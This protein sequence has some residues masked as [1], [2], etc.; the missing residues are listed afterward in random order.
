MR[1][2]VTGGA[3]FI[4]SHLV[5]ELICRGH[6]V[7]VLD[8]LSQ[9]DEGNIAHHLGSPAFEFIRGDVTE[10]S[11]V[12]EAVANSDAVYHLAAVVGVYY[13]L[14]DPI[15]TISVNTVGTEVVLRMAFRHK[16][17]VL[18]A[19]SSEVYGKRKGG[20]LS[21]GDDLVFGPTGVPRWCYALTKALDEHLALAYHRRGLEVSVVRYFNVYGPRLDPRGYGSVV[22]RF[23]TQA[24]DGRPITVYGDGTQTRSFTY[25]ADS[26]RGT[27]LAATLPQAVGRVFNIGNGREVSILEL[28]RLVKE[29]ACSPS[30]I[31]FV[32]YEQ[33]YGPD[34][35]EALR[36][37]PDTSRAEEV[38][39][40]RAQVPLEEGLR[41]TLDWFR[42]SYARGRGYAQV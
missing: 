27:I 17:R 42:E 20:P 34:F 41:K 36:R 15:R 25:V 14:Q 28:A 32:P 29:L 24:L 37:I 6:Y 18:V 7:T 33:A 26:V 3:G 11:L 10:A 38:L 30:P 13:V 31:T 35:E 8:D 23:I 21:E 9:G 2:L 19:S 4:G 5:D 39:G 40:F 1:V 16:K 12:E 22:A